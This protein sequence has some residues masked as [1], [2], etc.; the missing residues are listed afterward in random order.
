MVW[1]C[2]SIC[3]AGGFWFA[4]YGQSGLRPQPGRDRSQ[5]LRLIVREYMPAREAVA[6]GRRF[7]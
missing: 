7:S 1:R 5:L 6:R 4:L 3:L 2:F